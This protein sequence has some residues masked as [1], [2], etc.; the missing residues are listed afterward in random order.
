MSYYF[1]LEFPE[2]FSSVGSSMWTGS[3]PRRLLRIAGLSLLV[4][5]SL[6]RALFI[7]VPSPDN[8]P[9]LGLVTPKTL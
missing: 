7:V 9:V 1:E 4:S 5:I 3:S 8:D 2:R 6:Y